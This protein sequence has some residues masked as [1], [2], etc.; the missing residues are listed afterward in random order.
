[1]IRSRT[2][3]RGP[4]SWCRASRATASSSADAAPS[5]GLARADVD[6]VAVHGD[7][8]GLEAR[9]SAASSRSGAAIRQTSRISR[10]TS[11]AST[12][13]TTNPLASRTISSSSWC[14]PSSSVGQLRQRLRP[15]RVDEEAADAQQGVVAGRA[16]APPAGRAAARAP[17]GSSRRR[18]RRR[19]SPRRAGA[20][21]PRGRRARRGGRSAARRRPRI[22]RGRRAGAW[23]AS[24]TSGSSTR[25]AMS[26]VDVEEAAVVEVGRRRCAR[27]PGGSAGREELGPAAYGAVGPGARPGRR[28]RSSARPLS[29]SRRVERSSSPA[30]STSSSGAPR[31]GMRIV[32]SCASQSTS[33]QWA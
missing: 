3:G 18:P 4:G 30:A 7:E 23:V 17:R 10:L 2:A 19:R 15:G 12:C 29:P 26:E 33:N 31:T 20:G 5:S 8:Q 27:T 21:S 22:A 14:S 11:A 28:G 25:T 13:S 6:A 32:P 9:R 24:K 1:M 16:G